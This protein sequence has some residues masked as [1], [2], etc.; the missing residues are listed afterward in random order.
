MTTASGERLDDMDPQPSK[1]EASGEAST[2]SRRPRVRLGAVL[3]LAIGAGLVAWAIVDHR[4]S[5]SSSPLGATAAAG[6]TA[7]ASARP[8]A[9]VGLSAKGL[10]TLTASINQPI[11]W[12]GPKPGYLYELTRTSTGKIF[13]RYLPAGAKV[14]SKKAIYLIV[15]TYPFRNALQAL[16]NL[17]GSSQLT[18]PGGGIAIVDRTHPQSVHLAYPGVDNQVEVY[19]PSPAQ[20]LRIAR[21][22]KVRPV[23][24]P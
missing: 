7:A 24:T 8:I 3:A 9:P 4:G 11:Y 5:G 6:T 16:K 1:P 15:A 23:T 20:S 13:V 18:I 2:R 21:S 17:T 19:D 12:A 22:G 14:G 10:R